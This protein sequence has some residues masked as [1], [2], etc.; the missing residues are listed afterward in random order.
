LKQLNSIAAASILIWVTG[1][2]STSTVVVQDRVG[3]CHKVVAAA[4]S[5][6]SLQVSTARAQ[7]FTDLNAE[8]QLWN[9]DYGKNEFLYTAA[10]TDYAILGPDGTRIKRVRN[11]RGLNDEVPTAVILPAGSYTIVAQ[12]EQ[13]AGVNMEVVIPVAIESGQATTVHLEPE[14]TPAGEAM[15]SER[16]VRLADGRVLGCRAQSLVTQSLY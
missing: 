11:S 15:D 3:P 13:A 9:N 7:A 1:C 10:H 6:G 5:D 2:A 16:L 8:T 4:A 12:A 14:W